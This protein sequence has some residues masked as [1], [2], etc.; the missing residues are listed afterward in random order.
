MSS[1]RDK[2]SGKGT[3]SDASVKEVLQDAFFAAAAASATIG[4]LELILA[5]ASSSA[6]SFRAAVRHHDLNATASLLQLVAALNRAP[7]EESRKK[8]KTVLIREPRADGAPVV[9]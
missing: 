2:T 3:V 1:D 4:A 7:V 6:E 5:S 9:T 8:V